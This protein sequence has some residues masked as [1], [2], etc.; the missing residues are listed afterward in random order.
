MLRLLMG[1]SGSGKTTAITE[2]L[3]AV[4]ASAVLLVPEQFSFETE[5]FLL[6]RLGERGAAQ[7]QVLSFTRLADTVFREL[8][9]TAGR[10]MDEASRTLLMSAALWQT[11]DRLTMFARNG[12]ST[13][14]D[15]NGILTFLSECKQCAITSDMLR[16]Y[17]ARLGTGSLSTKMQELALVFDAFSALTAQAT[18]LDP[19]DDLSALAEKLPFSKIV[20]GKPVYVDAFDGFTHQELRV[21]GILMR[22]ASD[23]T[24]TL[25][26]DTL[27]DAHGGRLD[28]VRET[29]RQLIALARENNV[30]VASP[31][32]L[33]EN[34]RTQRAE[35]LAVEQGCFDPE[36]LPCEQSDAV[37]IIEC[38]RIA[39]ECRFA[40]RTIRRML[41]ENGGRCRDYAIVVRDLNAV[42]GVLDIALE[43]QGLPFYMDVRQPV[44]TDPLPSLLLG[45][46][47]CA[48]SGWDSEALLRM[49]KT[50][51]CGADVAA[52]G[53]LDQYIAMWRITGSAWKKP[54]TANPDGFSAPITEKTTALLERLNALRCQIAEPLLRLE[55]TLS[56]S[57]N[58]RD[59]A[60]ALYTYLVE[61]DVP[62]HVR[63][64]A[65]RLMA[66]GET[67]LAQRA[68]RIWDLTMQLFDRFAAVFA[69]TTFPGERAADL[70]GLLFDTVDLGSLPAGA[71]SI[72]VGAADRM[73]FSR[74]KTVFILGA[75]EGLF[76]AYPADNGIFSGR[77]RQLM[78]AQG[79][80]L[81]GDLLQESSRERYLA[82]R[83][84]AAPSERLFVSYSRSGS[85]GEALSPS[86]IVQEIHRLVPSA[87]HF[88]D[89]TDER[90]E[91]PEDAFEKIAAAWHQPDTET[92]AYREALANFPNCAPRLDALE[93]AADR[94]EQPMRLKE[95]AARLYSGSLHFSPTQTDTF[96]RCRFRHFC[97]Y[98]LYIR[99]R[100][101]ADLS[102]LETGT[103]VHYVLE[104]LLPVYAENHFDVSAVQARKDAEETVEEYIQ[105]F[106][107]GLQ[108]K[109]SPRR[110]AFLVRRLAAMCGD[111][112]WRV[113]TELREGGFEPMDYELPVGG[114]NGAPAWSVTLSDGTSLRVTGKIDR[115]DVYTAVHGDRTQRFIRVVDY[116]TGNKSFRLAQIVEG[117]DLQML[118]YLF[119]LCDENGRYADA[120]PAGVLYL[121]AKRPSSSGTRHDVRG[122]WCAD[123]LLLDDEEVLTAM[124]PVPEGKYIP[125]KRKKD[126]TWQ[127]TDALASA[128][129]MERLRRHA[130]RLLQRMA[131]TL[132]EGD[133]AVLPVKDAH[134]D[135][136]D[137]RAVCGF[138]EGDPVRSVADEKNADVLKRLEDCGDE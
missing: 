95:T 136:C 72:Q 17:A 128:Q 42:R 84:L 59:F 12:N 56:S 110:L 120:R 51:L 100:Q 85:E 111:L 44:R 64:L 65:R 108:D 33:Y 6:D 68:L 133:I 116:K 123:G 11:A 89:L 79:L 87:L 3:A 60:A 134:C 21:L 35:L 9:G 135:T 81:T 132:R 130:E 76:P 69:N 93:R 74:P 82:Y 52:I 70:I 49:L 92:A 126:G 29:A 90:I 109:P 103:L 41:R 107:G 117:M 13:V 20:A 22:Q 78:T 102:F 15:V 1:R 91:R 26:V 114:E 53:E 97:R 32:Y 7:V 28:F 75:N 121:P 88:N 96:H 86:A 47:Q 124:E 94:T 39:S 104:R 37:G 71:D 43:Q 80:P 66:Q 38:D 125:L 48:S 131:Q 8:G 58:G 113:V 55:K 36:A 30:P 19:L 122:K 62:T 138:E 45:A 24:V 129:D 99:G 73:R 77:E 40:A 137:Y 101:T 23:V 54:F 106:V 119:A 14:A 16:E 105:T 67:A 34:H 127:K 112:L 2:E 25:C 115:V 57:L 61:T 63:S 83:A 4:D 10:R 50:G 98:A 5:K 46:L 18:L 31:R 118:L 27:D